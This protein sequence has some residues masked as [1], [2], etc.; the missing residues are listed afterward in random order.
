M[1]G[2]D[3]QVTG[4]VKQFGTMTVLDGL[5]LTVP[6]GS[7]VAVLGSS[8]SGKTTLLRVIA[9][10]E[11]VD[12]GSVSIAGQLVSDA[13]HSVPP[14]RRRIGIVPQEGALFPHLSVA[15]N[16]GFGLPRSSR[17]SGR[18]EDLLALVGLAGMGGRRPQDLSGGQQQRVALA[19]AL[20]P[21]PALVLLD[22]PFAALDAGLRTSLAADVRRVLHASGTTAVLVTHDQEEALGLADLVAVLRQGRIVQVADPKTLYC[23]PVDAD[24][25]H[26][27]GEATLLPGCRAGGCVEC[28]L[29]CLPL[30]EGARSPDGPSTIMVRPEQIRLGAPEGWPATVRDVTYF[31]HDALAT[32][33]VD[34]TEGAP[35]TEVL[36]RMPGMAA[37]RAG[38]MVHG[39][40][41]GPVVAWLAPGSVPDD[42]SA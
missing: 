2:A 39:R 9:G 8:G 16:V 14:E 37:P 33:V 3:L 18:V 12:A 25:A 13:R 19:R 4:V 42:G 27:V 32:L 31:G 30:R 41:E 22:E 24:V 23:A 1:D 21:A 20:A 6:T 28:A 15:A 11:H 5:D 35:T 17:R 36:A 7:L 29:G 38:D 10:F 34:A 40:V 26:F